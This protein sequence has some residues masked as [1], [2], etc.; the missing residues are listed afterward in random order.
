[1]TEL[2]FECAGAEVERY[3]AAPTL[4]L[5]LHVAEAT[6]QA[7]HS[8]MLQCQIRIQPRQRGYSDTEAENL[9][10]LYGEPGRWGQTLR[11]LQLAQV[12]LVVPPFQ[13]ET[14]ANLPVPFTYDFEV[15]STKYLH[16][17]RDGE[18]PLEL[19]FSG[20]VFR[21]A[22]QA[23]PSTRCRGTARPPTGSRCACGGR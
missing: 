1:M 18:I 22:P 13:G 23:S 6:G 4:N 16:G 11:P 9:R 8:I 3:A 5:R 2:G 19:L 21:K 10:D 14:E 15:A 20:T 7:I 17:L 12:P